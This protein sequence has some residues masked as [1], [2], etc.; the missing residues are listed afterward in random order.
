MTFASILFF[1]TINRK[2]EASRNVL[3]HQIYDL[4]QSSKSASK[5]KM[6]F[7]STPNQQLAK[8]ATCTR[9]RQ[10]SRIKRARNLNYQNKEWGFPR[11]PEPKK[12]RKDRRRDQ[13]P[14]LPGEELVLVD[15]SSAAL[16]G[17]A[18]PLLPLVRNDHLG[19]LLLACKESDRTTNTT[20]SAKN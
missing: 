1:Y 18:G 3:Y 10:K 9:G 7:W 4:Q 20:S 14:V 5:I 16:G 15:L 19:Q 6:E 11:E 8:E 12:R 13:G 17:V 2:N